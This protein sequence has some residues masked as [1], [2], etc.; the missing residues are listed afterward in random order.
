[1]VFHVYIGDLLSRTR[2]ESPRRIDGN[3]LGEKQVS[4]SRGTRVVGFPF[5]FPPPPPPPPLLFFI[6]LS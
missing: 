3:I 2:L 6:E 5:P 1:M 4:S